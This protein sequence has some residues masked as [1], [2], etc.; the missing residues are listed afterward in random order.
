MLP[1]P[2]LSCLFLGCSKGG[3]SLDAG[4]ALLP[5]QEKHEPRSRSSL[6]WVNVPGLA[7]LEHFLLKIPHTA[8]GQV[9]TPSQAST[10]LLPLHEAAVG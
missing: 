9:P 6:L 2:S 4:L 1:A 8:R 3:G 7:G 5:R 10:A